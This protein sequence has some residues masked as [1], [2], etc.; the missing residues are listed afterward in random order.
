[1]A[2]SINELAS[3]IVEL[4]KE[5][6]MSISGISAKLKI[7]WRTAASYLKLLKDLGLA[8]EQAIK[9]KRIFFYLDKDNYF[10][11]PIKPKDKA[12]ITTIYALI[13]KF[14]IEKFNKEPTKT[15]A[16][17]ILW[18]IN[19]T[20]NLNLPIGW[21]KYGPLSIQAYKGD[22]KEEIKLSYEKD[23]KKITEEY[24]GLNSI[25]LQ[26]KIYK[27]ENKRLYLIKKNLIENALN[28]R[29]D[30]L[31][32]LLIDLIKNVPEEAKDTATDYVRAMLLLGP[33]VM[34]QY[35]GLFWEYISM[36]I[37]KDS[38][39]GHY[40]PEIYMQDRIESAKKDIELLLDDIIKK[41]MD[42]KYSQDELYQ[43]WVKGKR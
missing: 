43:R 19:K 40:D 32:L 4:L 23:I 20:L 6:P 13:R 27:E 2:E 39:K 16:H 22:E 15:Q 21:Y 31:N 7:N 25:E 1:M 14:C 5:S 26:N 28:L 36:I 42:A 17:K 18:K 3:S 34:M 29:K 10:N 35:F 11:L 8:R 24:C 12:T 9:N 37:L 41:Y 38:I 33:K 30:E